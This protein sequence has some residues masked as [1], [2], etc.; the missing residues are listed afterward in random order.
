MNQNRKHTPDNNDAIGDIISWVIVFISM[1]AF[2][3]IGVFLL[4]KKDKNQP[5]SKSAQSSTAQTCAP[6]GT[7]KQKDKS[8]LQRRTGKFVSVVLLLNAIALLII[9]VNSVLRA[10]VGND[11]YIRITELTMGGFFIVGAVVS[12]CSRNIVARRIS[13]Y[14][15]YHAFVAGRDIVPVGDIVRIAG[16]ST[17]T[18][19]RD[20]QAMIDAGYF[21]SGAFIDSELQSLVM[22]TDASQLA[23]RYRPAQTSEH[24]TETKT[25]NQYM[26]ILHELRELNRTVADISITVKIERI[27]ELAAKIFRHVEEHPEKQPQIRRFLS[28]YL[29]TTKKLIRSYATL[30]RQG[31][32][33]ENITAAKENISRTLDTL[34]V[35]F[36]QQLDQLFK[37]NVIDISAD[38][39]V[40]ETL[41]QQDGLIGDQIIEDR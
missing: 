17:A 7:A 3:P 9:G 36:E 14:K 4:W 25:D 29:P 33:G 20:I 21:G 23:R 35:G 2:W 24:Q 11:G 39:N 19:T 40:I 41:L 22:S 1:F 12:F 6:V 8:P 34:G 18:V 31:I 10:T 27:E 5:V 16:L 15:K 26:S 32:G 38:S 13:R 28:Y 37:A 30:E